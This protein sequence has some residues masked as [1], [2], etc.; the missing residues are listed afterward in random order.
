MANRF[1]TIQAQSELLELFGIKLAVRTKHGLHARSRGRLFRD[2]VKL[3]AVA[4][5]EQCELTQALHLLELFTQ[6]SGHFRSERESF[7]HG[8]GCG[9]VRR[10]DDKEAFVVHRGTT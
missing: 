9:V 8:E 7:T 5:V 2:A 10:T 1:Q 4:R 6:R 3:D